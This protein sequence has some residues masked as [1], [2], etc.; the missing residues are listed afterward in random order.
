MRYSNTYIKDYKKNLDKTEN[1]TILKKGLKCKSDDCD[2]EVLEEDVNEKVIGDNIIVKRTNVKIADDE[3]DIEVDEDTEVGDDDEIDLDDVDIE[4]DDDSD[5]VSVDDIV[6]NDT[7][8]DVELTDDEGSITNDLKLNNKVVETKNS[9]SIKKAIKVTQKTNVPMPE[10]IKVINEVDTAVITP[11]IDKVIKES[12]DKV[13][14]DPLNIKNVK[15]QDIKISSAIKAGEQLKLAKDLETMED[16]STSA[17]AINNI[18]KQ[19]TKINTIKKS[20][21]LEKESTKKLMEGDKPKAKALMQKAESERTKTDIIMNADNIEKAVNESIANKIIVSNRDIANVNDQKAKAAIVLDGQTA[22]KELKEKTNL[23]KTDVK[24]IKKAVAKSDIIV[25]N[26]LSTDKAVK[27]VSIKPSVAK[28]VEEL[29]KKSDILV[30]SVIDNNKKSDVKSDIIAQNHVDNK[31][32]SV[33]KP[34]INTINRNKIVE[35]VIINNK[36]LKDKS[37]NAE[38]IKKS[39]DKIDDIVK[40]KILESESNKTKKKL[41]EELINKVVKKEV[42]EQAVDKV[43]KKEMKKS[44]LSEDDSIKTKPSQIVKKSV[45][46]IIKSKLPVEIKNKKEIKK[47]V[48]DA[49][50]NKINIGNIVIHNN[51]GLMNNVDKLKDAYLYDQKVKKEEMI[52]NAHRVYGVNHNDKKHMNRYQSSK[53]QGYVDDDINKFN[54]VNAF[55]NTKNFCGTDSVYDTISCFNLNNPNIIVDKVK[56]S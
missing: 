47:D 23:D 6:S 32:T 7:D 9:S 42:A 2:E 31:D 52:E 10:T 17:D 37:A 51:S 4:I 18:H 38:E 26:K 24:E 15:N 53:L 46:K 55:G 19:D 45:D 1:M 44:Q 14:K 16:Y 43:I 39:E 28:K 35:K 21:K 34:S 33:N 5:V 49:V 12:V 11:K 3:V 41:G 48:L 27:D 20:E 56:P 29:K 36:D 50:R 40:G 13:V 22:N 25:A 54:C 30:E 8:T